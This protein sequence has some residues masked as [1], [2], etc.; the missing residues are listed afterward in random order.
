MMFEVQAIY[1]KVPIKFVLTAMDLD[2]TS[3]ARISP[4]NDQG[5]S[6]Y[7][8]L[9]EYLNLYILPATRPPLIVYESLVV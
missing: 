2:G 5:P 7:M 9:A 4:Y 6:P 8:F 3:A 1:T